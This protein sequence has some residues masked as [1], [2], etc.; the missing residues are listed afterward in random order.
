MQELKEF[1]EKRI[2]RCEQELA[3]LS[4]K[5]DIEII[6]YNEEEGYIKLINFQLF[7]SKTAPRNELF[8]Q[9]KHNQNSN[10]ENSS[11]CF[12]F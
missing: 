1:L 10:K 7:E 8:L 2:E 3:S 5:D 4:N 6:S 12:I 11:I 9:K